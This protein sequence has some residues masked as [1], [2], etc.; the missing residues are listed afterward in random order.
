MAYGIPPAWLIVGDEV[1]QPFVPD[2]STAIISIEPVGMIPDLPAVALTA[3]DPAVIV[4]AWP[5][6]DFQAVLGPWTRDSGLFAPTTQPASE[7][8]SNDNTTVLILEPI[9][10]PGEQRLDVTLTFPLR[11]LADVSSRQGDV[12]FVWRLNVVSPPE[13][14]PVTNV[15]STSTADPGASF[16]LPPLPAFAGP[17]IGGEVSFVNSLAE[18]TYR[19][20]VDLPAEQSTAPVLLAPNAMQFSPDQ[21][22]TYPKKAK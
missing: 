8:Q 15:Q 6:N 20:D 2:Y 11:R 21:L 10:E 5:V 9:S 14:T 4:V 16:E 19:L 13:P 22:R 17:A 18:A 1:F 7:A 12:R 3:G